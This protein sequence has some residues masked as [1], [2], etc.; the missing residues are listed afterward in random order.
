MG[1]AIVRV[2]ATSH[3]TSTNPIS[4]APLDLTASKHKTRAALRAGGGL[5]QAFYGPWH[6]RLDYRF[7][8]YGTVR[9]QGF[10]SAV[11]GVIGLVSLSI[12]SKIHPRDHALTLGLSRY[13]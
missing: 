12:D 1:T 4:A 2:E 13:F 3:S 7:T 9:V 8:D 11:E 5:E 10:T 6:L